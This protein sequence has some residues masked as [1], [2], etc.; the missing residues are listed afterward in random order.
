MNVPK[1]GP[2]QHAVRVMRMLARMGIQ[3]QFQCAAIHKLRRAYG[4]LLYPPPL[5]STRPTC[6]C[7]TQAYP[8]S[9]QW[10][11]PSPCPHALPRT[12][13]HT[14]LTSSFAAHSLMKPIMTCVPD[15]PH[16]KGVLGGG[17]DD[18]H[19]DLGL[20]ACVCVR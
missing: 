4:F 16:V 15:G 19:H 12:W 3:F 7:G 20:A 18:V 2:L 10:R 9:E 17:V 5:L 8:A 14:I 6:A 1:L 13:E 11:P